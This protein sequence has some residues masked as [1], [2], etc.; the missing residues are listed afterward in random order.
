MSRE[1]MTTMDL[2]KE[3]KWNR[4]EFLSEQCINEQ[5]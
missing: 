1:K 4:A 2:K 3:R 5:V